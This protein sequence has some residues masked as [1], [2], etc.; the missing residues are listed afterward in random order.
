MGEHR[1][2]SLSRLSRDQVDSS[3]NLGIPVSQ[4]ATL[5]D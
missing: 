3:P 1:Q 2:E 5:V 4:K